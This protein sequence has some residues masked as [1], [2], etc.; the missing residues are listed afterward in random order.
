MATRREVLRVVRE[1]YVG[2]SRSKKSRILDEFVAVT[3]Y[4]RKHAIRLLNQQEDEVDT[5]PRVGRRIYDEAVREAL[6]IVWETADRICG[7][8]LKAALPSL[9]EAMERHGHLRLDGEVRR[10]LLAVSASTI[11][12]LLA[13]IREEAGRRKRRTGATSA[14][15]K[16][17][18]VR[19]FGDWGDPSPGFFEGDLVAHCGGSMAGSFV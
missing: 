4:H 9:V 17:V 6:I 14:I 10:L 11:D 8:R 2:K 16:K 15:R 1:R 18:P 12:R 5:P 7:K 19:T 3:G 13:P